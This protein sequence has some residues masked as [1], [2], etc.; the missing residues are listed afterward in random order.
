LQ[1]SRDYGATATRL[2]KMSSEKRRNV[3]QLKTLT[4]KVVSTGTIE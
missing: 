4:K 2:Y 1:D 3:N